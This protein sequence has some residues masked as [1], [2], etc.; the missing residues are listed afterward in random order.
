MIKK[1]TAIL[2]TAALCLGLCSGCNGK[3]EEET[4]SPAENTTQPISPTAQAKLVYSKNDSLNPFEAE[5]SVNIR[6]MSLIY[7]GLFSLDSTY[8]LRPSVGASCT[9]GEGVLT[10]NLDASVR[11]SDGSS[12]TV[13]DVVYSFDEAKD[14]YA[15]QERLRNFTA[16]TAPDAHS[17]MFTLETPNPFAENCLTFP[18][19][20]EGSDEERPLGTGRYIIE[21]G[22]KL[23][24]KKN[25]YHSNFTPQM[26]CIELTEIKDPSAVG[27]SLEI[28]NTCF[29][30][31]ELTEGAYTRVNASTTDVLLNN[32]VYLGV[33]GEDEVLSSPLVR[34]AVNSAVN[35]QEIVTT[36]FQ[37]HAKA[38]YT[39]FNPDWHRIA[40]SVDEVVTES[41]TPEE[42]IEQSGVNLDGRSFS[43]LVNSD[44]AFKK[45]AAKMIAEDL[46][47]IGLPTV[48]NAL[49]YESYLETVKNGGY[50]FY[51]GEIRLTADMDI[52]DLFW[53]GTCD[54]GMTEEIQAK[55]YERYTQLRRGDCELMDFVNTYAEEYPFIPVCYRG[56]IAAYTNALERSGSPCC[57]A[58]V[59]CNIET[60]EIVKQ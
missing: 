1:I 12:V 11:F 53:G 39:P 54:Y 43:L 59:Y 25:Q 2:L 51:I 57:D 50:D 35:R 4:T 28:G 48:V 13:E 16:A 45:E 7:D 5:T 32:F 17:V 56:A 8:T 20:K 29:S 18:I 38:A 41:M 34:R 46:T 27:S 33:D 10:V 42:L 24:L 9:A 30:F 47:A 40:G 23:L 19:V 21:K 58:D 31:D 3:T 15:Y 6:L 55:S 60:W 26:T 22:S 36:A 52:S 44:N 14:S 49:P 37:G